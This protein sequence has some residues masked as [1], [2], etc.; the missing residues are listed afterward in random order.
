M[1]KE[2][3]FKRRVR[4]RIAKTGESYTA[5]RR[6]VSQKRDHV[7]AARAR[8]GATADRPSDEKVGAVTGKRW[9][10]WFSILD[11]SGARKR[12]HGE[13][14]AFLMEEHEVPGWWAQSITMW[15]ERARGIRLKHQ[16][17]D[18]FTIYASK[19]M[20]VPLEVLF[21]AFVNPRSRRTWLTD[22]TMSLR[23]SQPGPH[24]SLRLGGRLDAGERLVRRQGPG[25]G[26]GRGGT[27]TA[28]G[29]RRGRKGE[30]L[31]AGAAGRPQVI[32]RGEVTTMSARDTSE[33]KR[34]V[35]LR[36]LAYV[37]SPRWHDDRLWF[38]HWGT[39]Q[40]VAVDLDGVSEVVGDGPPG[41]GWSIGWL[42]DGRL[43][44]TGE[45]LMRRE[46][47]G[48]MVQHA[49]LSALSDDWNE[50]VVDGRGNIYVN[51]RCDFDPGDGDPPGI[52][53]LV[54]PDGSVRQV[55]DGIAFPNG[56]IVTPDNSTL[57][58]AES[59]AGRLT[60]FD[61]AADGG[62]SGRGTWARLHDDYPDGICLDTDGAVWYADVPNRHCVRVR[63]GGEVLQTIDLDRSP[64]ACMLGGPDGRTL[65]MLAA[66]WRGFEKV[67]EALAARTGQVLTVRAPVARAGWP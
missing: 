59:F 29:S 27:R 22:G 14:V 48:S 67:D 30:G 16:Q 33:D 46:P 50:I 65:F 7:Q 61:I 10:A 62:L 44:V 38:A 42:P 51:G 45:R 66:E 20:A 12:K 4:G 64:F 47:D 39:G 53:A 2:R 54:T 52:I 1:T 56:M 9:E 13:T 15:Y 60:A 31:V 58:V 40:V 55:A 18:G 36:G 32:P 23:T 3:L 6:Q 19:T 63:E 24:G 26:D 41:L 35:L 21:D 5:A 28:P 49:D 11:R 25:E 37:E 8:L 57:I 17:A 34:R 43:L